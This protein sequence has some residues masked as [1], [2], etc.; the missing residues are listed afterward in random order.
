MDSQRLVKVSKYLSKHLRHQPE[1]LGLTLAPGGWVSVDELLRACGDHQF[2]I[3]RDELD[4]VVASNDK[5]R[6]SFDASG[7]SIR[8]NQGHTTAVDL[9]LEPMT[10]PALL[11]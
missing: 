2:S 9:Q 11:Y 4:K 7:E 3:T 6:F 10:P 1:R 5:H 8:A